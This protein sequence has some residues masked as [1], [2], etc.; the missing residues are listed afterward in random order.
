MALPYGIQFPANPGADTNRKPGLQ[1]VPPRNPGMYGGN[2]G[3]SNQA[4]V[5][6]SSAPQVPGPLPGPESPFAKPMPAIPDPNQFTAYGTPNPAWRPP[7]PGVIPPT[8]KPGRPSVPVSNPIA[9]GLPSN[10]NTAQAPGMPG[11]GVT[12][13][14]RPTRENIASLYPQGGSMSP[15]GNYFRPNMPIG[16][17]GTMQAQVMPP[18]VWLGEG[19]DPLTQMPPMGLFP[20][21]DQYGGDRLGT[22]PAP[23]FNGGKNPGFQGVVNPQDQMRQY[24]QRQSAPIPASAQPNTG[25]NPNGG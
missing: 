20:Q 21:Y 10:G 19:V 23:R 9:G 17:P 25:K 18:P 3:F 6:N 14:T 2:I 11:G 24:P 4:Q 12:Q 16:E 22:N 7:V 15:D 1:P 13:S 5:G 8:D